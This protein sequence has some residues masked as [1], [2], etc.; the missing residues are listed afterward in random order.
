[1]FKKCKARIK[2]C[3]LCVLASFLTMQVPVALAADPTYIVAPCMENIGTASCAVTIRN[4]SASISAFVSG[5]SLSVNKCQIVIRLQKK[6]G[7]TW[8]TMRSW[9]ET[10]ESNSLK[11]T[12]SATVSGGNTYRVVADCTVWKNGIAETVTRTSAAKKC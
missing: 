9:T 5:N 12:K 6:T 8:Y 10:K 4:Q 1:M 7:S 2:V 11:V 3:S